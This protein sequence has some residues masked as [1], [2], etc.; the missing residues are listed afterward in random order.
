MSLRLFWPSVYR[1]APEC[2]CLSCSVCALTYQN[3]PEAWYERRY[4]PTV[5][6]TLLAIGLF[7][8]YLRIGIYP[9]LWLSVA[10]IASALIGTVVD[11]YSTLRLSQMKSLFDQRGVHFP[12]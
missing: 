1:K 3:D 8:I 5:V 4:L 11:D 2:S 9:R 12:F 10:G 6:D 7:W